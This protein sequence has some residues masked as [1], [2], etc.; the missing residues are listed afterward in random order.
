M[1]I[2]SITL[3]L[4]LTS[5]FAG[6][7]LKKIKK[8]GHI[9]CGV[10]TGLAGFSAP[11]SKGNWKGLDVDFCRAFATSVFGDPSKVK[12]VSLSAQQRFTA[13]QSGEVDVLSRNT[14]F[15]LGR[16]TSL[17][18]N[19]APVTYYDG[20]G[21]M[22]RKKDGIKSLKEL[23]GA[24]VCTQQGTTTELNVADYFRANK[25]K[26]KPVVFESNEEVVAAYLKGRCDAYTTDASGLASERSKLKNPNDH[27]ILSE[28]ISKEPL[29]P[30][31]RH[32]DD[33]W[34]DI[35]KWTVYSIIE[36]EEVGIT[37]K[38]INSFSKSSDPKI[39]R[40]LGKIKGNGKA[41]GLKESWA[42]DV[43][44]KVGNYSEI[45]ERNVGQQSALKLERGLN[46]QW[47][48]GG[49]M[50]APPLR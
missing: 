23:N 14:T 29:G 32:G 46:A 39:K 37:S 5:A 38:N 17:G 4:L 20:Q 2:I 44:L 49:L 24:S 45:F 6:P 1:K 50:Y 33:S 35:V 22:V 36:A 11:D 18:L 21:F 25:M 8:Q 19:F 28:I 13:L 3:A 41:L 16:D 26:Y 34:F 30:A 27:V 9:K 7:T 31:V 42:K 43:I 10:S 40:F 12:Y 15:T 47:N 48:K